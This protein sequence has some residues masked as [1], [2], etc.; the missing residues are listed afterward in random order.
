[1][2]KFINIQKAM[3]IVEWERNMMMILATFKSQENLLDPQGLVLRIEHIYINDSFLY[4]DT[5]QAG[6]KKCCKSVG[7][8]VC[9][10][11]E[12]FT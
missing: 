6:D 11:V 1:M 3:L 4:D 10:H 2:K 5:I 9:I 12:Q 7:I 8:H